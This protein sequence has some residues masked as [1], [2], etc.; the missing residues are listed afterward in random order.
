[1]GKDLK[2]KEL[3]QGLSQRKDGLYSARV[4]VNGKRIEKYFKNITEARKYLVTIK[5]ENE[6]NILQSN[7]CT[8]NEWFYKW[9]NIYK[10]DTVKDA[11]YK[12]YVNSFEKHIKSKIGFMLLQ[13]VKQ[14]YCQEILNEMYDKNFAYGTMILV[15][16]TMHALFDGAVSEELIYKNP[17]TKNVKCRQRET[18]E[19]RVLTLSEQKEFV[20]YAEKSIY[21]NA[22]QLALNTGLRSGEIGGLRWSDI[23][24]DK[25][26]VFINRTLL[27]DK[28]KG[29]F[30]FGSPKSKDSKRG[31]PLTNTVVDLLNSQKILQFKL[32]GNSNNWNDNELYKDLVFTSINGNPCGHS[33]FNNNIMRIITN[34]N[35]DRRTISLLNNENFIEFNPISMHTLR[36]TFAT[37]C[38]ECGVKPKNLQKILGHSSISVTMDLYVHALDEDNS[39]EMKKFE[40]NYK[41]NM[42][43]K[44]GVI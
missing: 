11:T 8:V 4:V 14:I 6:H 43:R 35:K 44:N 21:F 15:R 32:R 30:Y 38:I 29:G 13:E 26:I 19:K 31:V 24:Y 25:K 16:I 41:T 42:W 23:D 9:V 17:V 1:M 20:K 28:N 33:T 39:K 40:E 18:E 3:G 34:I 2:G 36:H 5:Y 7:N 27:F 37:R 12:N 10:K 22:Y